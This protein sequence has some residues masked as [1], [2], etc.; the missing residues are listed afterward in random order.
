MATTAALNF[1]FEVDGVSATLD[2]LRFSGNECLSELFR[3]EIDLSSAEAGLEWADTVGKAAVL[4]LAMADGERRIHGIVTSFEE[5]G[6]SKKKTFYTA[7][8]EPKL[9]LLTQRRQC[10]IF[11]AKATPDILKA[12]FAGVGITGDAV[13]YRLSGDYG[14]RSFCVQ[15]RESDYDFAQ[16]LMEEEGI[17]YHFEHGDDE[18]LLVISDHAEARTEIPGESTLQHR[19]PDAAV[20][21]DECVMGFGCTRTFRPGAV[22]LR[23]YDFKKPTLSLEGRYEDGG[24]R[25][26]AIE[27]YDFPGEFHDSTLGSS[28]AQSRLEEERAESWL[29]RAESNCTRFTPGGLFSLEGHW[30][31]DLHQQY[32]IVRV[33][34]RGRTSLDDGDNTSGMRPGETYRNTFEFIPADVCWRPPRVT[35]RPVIE[36]SQSAIVTGPKGEEIH[37]DEFGRVKLRFHWDRT[38][39]QDDKS[40]WW[41][42]VSQL[43]GGGGYGGMFVPRVGTEVIVDFFEGDPDRP[44][45]TGRIFHGEHPLPFQ[46]PGAKSKTTINP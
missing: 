36:G 38:D 15:Y 28:L 43:W 34:H 41:V 11:Q 30:R 40:S 16:R 21:E 19:D 39:P 17:A 26:T 12:V 13:E 24:E 18:S 3:F 42:Q 27:L 10:R 14:P 7:T 25:E 29:G 2:V 22:V 5:S 32:L 1:A 23:D 4:V 8:L 6:Q 45:V 9:W 31:E 33:A 37:C 46:L 44:I 20:G 35:P